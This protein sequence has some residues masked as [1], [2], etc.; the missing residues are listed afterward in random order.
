MVVKTVICR[1]GLLDIATRWQYS[2][3]EKFNIFKIR[4]IKRCLP[5]E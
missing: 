4:K 1:V 2:N 3:V 5:L